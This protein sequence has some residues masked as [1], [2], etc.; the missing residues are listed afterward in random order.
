MNRAKKKPPS[1]LLSGEQSG[2]VSLQV[3]VGVLKT[4]G[5]Y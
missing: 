2:Y 4:Y 3:E 5:F 1:V